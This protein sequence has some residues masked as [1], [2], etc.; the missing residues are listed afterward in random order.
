[1]I[2]NSLRAVIIFAACLLIAGTWPPFALAAGAMLAAGAVWRF[3]CKLRLGAPYLLAGA[4][5]V[6]AGPAL[7]LVA[8]NQDTTTISHNPI[9]YCQ[10]GQLN[11]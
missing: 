3:R 7:A 9:R 5:L 10:A 4:L 6:I 1:M 11:C 2:L 8:P